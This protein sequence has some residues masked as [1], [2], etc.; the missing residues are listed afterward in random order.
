MAPRDWMAHH[1]WTRLP[2]T[3]A[4]L[5]LGSV[6]M[7]AWEDSLVIST[8]I[9]RVGRLV[10]ACALIALVAEMG[11][12]RGIWAL[13][14]R[15]LTGPGRL[16][17]IAGLLTLA[18]VVLS[19]ET[20]GCQCGGGSYGL[21]EIAV[22]LALALIVA[23]AAPEARVALLAAA[24]TGCLV[25]AVLALAGAHGASTMAL[26]SGRL[27]GTYGNSNYFAATQA[28]G[29]P[30]AVAGLAQIR[31][32]LIRIAAFAFATTLTVALVLSY[33]RSGVLA[34]GAGVWATLVLLAPARRRL[35]VGAGL[36]AAAGLA[37]WL[38]YPTFARDRS[39]ADFA[40]A[41]GLYRQTDGSGWTRAETGLIAHGPSQMSNPQAGV[42][43]VVAARS[44]EG[45]SLPLG[46]ARPSVIYRL[47]FQARVTSGPG[48]MSFG[49]EDNLTGAGPVAA[50]SSP[51]RRWRA[52]SLSW[53]P[54]AA[55]DHAR[56]YFWTQTPGTF[57]LRALR[58]S[59]GRA[60]SAALPVRLLG[61]T[62][63]SPQQ[64]INRAES[65]YISSRQSAAR[66]AVD[67]FL[68]HPLVGVGWERFGRF[69]APRS[70][71]GAIATH[72]EYL[73]YAAELGVFGL[74]AIILLCAAV[75]WAVLDAR[76]SGLGPVLIGVVVTA[77]IE[78]AFSNILESPD[79]VLPVATA[80]A[81]A[82]AISEQARARRRSYA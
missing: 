13:R 1:G 2:V 71:L 28:L 27:A 11:G 76:V 69:A 60:A 50:T 7:F 47:R 38:L 36:I 74:V 24:G 75:G 59:I 82:S 46:R 14:G 72:N 53:R 4:I 32:P 15:V 58:W 25:A 66:I 78:L 62:G 12:I 22:W 34:A 40:Y 79:V 49:L 29:L 56:A 8:P 55:A 61:H 37:G 20:N 39:S 6:G 77:A 16:L 43:R 31:V 51:D 3:T 80:V 70:G 21:I 63:A 44:D 73:R 5:A 68:A 64:Q 18:L 10:L 35:A 26:G 9:T 65:R 52:V 54:R 45:V 41:L 81:I 23:V 57:E 42:L 67:A 19:S 17:V 33:S 48:P 30:L